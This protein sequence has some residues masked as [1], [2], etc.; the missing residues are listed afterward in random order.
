MNDTS[1]LDSGSKAG[2]SESATSTRHPE[3]AKAP[4]KVTGAVTRT[5]SLERIE[6]SFRGEVPT[7]ETL[8]TREGAVN[9]SRFDGVH[10]FVLSPY[11]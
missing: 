2:S 3:S 1:R 6:V 4:S 7:S 9:Y 11:R 8:T 10:R 5:K